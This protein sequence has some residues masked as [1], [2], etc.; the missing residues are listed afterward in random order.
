AGY[1]R[2]YLI[3]Q[4]KAAPATKANIEQFKTRRAELEKASAARLSEAQQRAEKISALK[5]TLASKAGDEGKLFGSIGPRDIA[6]GATKEGVALKKSEVLMPEGPLRSVGQHEIHVRLH[7]N[8][9]AVLNVTIV[10]QE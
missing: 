4:G 2:N 6:E 5:L 3:P 1:G 10:S 7:T 9:H 8:V